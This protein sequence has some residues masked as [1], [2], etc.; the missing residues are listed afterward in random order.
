[1]ILRRW[2]AFSVILMLGGCQWS[3]AM[4][5]GSSIDLSDARK[6]GDA[7][8]DDMIAD[9]VGQGLKRME[10]AFATLMPAAEAEKAMRGLFNYCGRPVDKEYKGTQVGFKFYPNGTKKPMRKLFYAATTTTEPKGVCFFGVEIVPEDNGLKVTTFG[11]LK[12]QSGTLPE[13]LK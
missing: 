13:P 6:V 7:F 1:M 9:Q 2:A 8:M 10:S 4:Q 5:S 3:Q 11:P 12:L